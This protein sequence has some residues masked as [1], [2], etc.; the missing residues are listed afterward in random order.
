MLAPGLAS[1]PK[2]ASSL[3]VTLF[4]CYHSSS[5]S[6]PSVALAAWC[7]LFLLLLHM[8]HCM[9]S[10]VA[11]GGPLHGVERCRGSNPPGDH[12]FLFEILVHDP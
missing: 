4:E 7:P 2:A 10:S 12:F 1:F 5:Q 3:C 6:A 8:P 9:V 11:V